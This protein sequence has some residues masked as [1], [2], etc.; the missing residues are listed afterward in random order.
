M[1]RAIT[2]VALLFGLSNSADADSDGYFCITETYLAYEYNLLGTPNSHRVAIV[3][4][5]E[6]TGTIEVF[7]F[8]LPEFQLHS[9]NC[10]DARIV[11]AG[12]DTIHEVT[13]EKSDPQATNV[14][15]RA[16]R[17]GPTELTTPPEFGNFLLDAPT[18]FSL[19]DSD[20]DTSYGL[21]VRRIRIAGMVCE[22]LV[23]ATLYRHRSDVGAGRRVLYSR[24]VPRECVRSESGA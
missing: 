19:I 1:A 20:S 18:D 9:L 17:P 3:P 10:G 22:D 23:T 13:W 5:D 15:S 11:L 12:W 21:V 24:D 2:V 6:D 7:E 8:G 16:K 4:F 14:N